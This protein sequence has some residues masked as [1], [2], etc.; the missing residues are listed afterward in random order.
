MCCGA[1]ENAGPGKCKTLKMTDEISE[2]VNA[3]PSCSGRANTA[4][5]RCISV[6]ICCGLCIYRQ[7]YGLRVCCGNDDDAAAGT[8]A[9]RGRRKTHVVLAAQY[10]RAFDDSAVL[11][12]AVISEQPPSL[13]KVNGGIVADTESSAADAVS[14]PVWNSE[15]TD[16]NL[17]SAAANAESDGFHDAADDTVD[18]DGNALKDIAVTPS[19][20]S[21][22]DPAEDTV[23]ADGDALKNSAVT[24]S[25]S[26]FQNEADD[27]LDAVD[28]DRTQENVADDIEN[29]VKAPVSD[30]NERT[31]ELISE[32]T[33]ADEISL[34]DDC[35][36]SHTGN[37]ESLTS[38]DDEL[39]GSATGALSDNCASSVSR[40]TVATQTPDR[41]AVT[42]DDSTSNA[43]EPVATL[44][45]IPLQE[46][47]S[48]SR[49]EA[50][51][52][53]RRWRSMGAGSRHRRAV[54]TTCCDKAVDVHE[55]DLRVQP[56]PEI[57]ADNE[58]D[59]LTEDATSEENGE[60]TVKE[61]IDE[62]KKTEDTLSAVSATAAESNLND[63]RTL[64]NLVLDF[65][66][67]GLL[68]TLDAK[69]E[70]VSS[71]IYC[72]TVFS[73]SYYS[74]N[75]LKKHRIYQAKRLHEI[76]PES[77]ELLLCTQRLYN[78]D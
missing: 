28:V 77:T 46:A 56:E 10:N 64:D 22:Q 58:T 33:S 43:H 67:L 32:R 68:N 65:D 38:A 20:I 61:E 23:D 42:D 1:N 74:I 35:A 29:D 37:R 50:L 5:R 16:W 62:E 4:R 15:L 39:S 69:Q 75:L 78:H 73:Q 26:K 30:S 17:D 14:V 3:C 9:H 13:V 27:T 60:E 34:S 57:V 49:R 31:D 66:D 40:N 54:G 48:T 52:L 41:S 55:D 12:P 53:D 44:R 36:T 71:L 11:C 18:A 2:L 59:A 7:Q 76:L 72:S 24:P 45:Q 47:H 6:Q 8:S 21:F 63:P 51:P 25:K 70:E 19:E